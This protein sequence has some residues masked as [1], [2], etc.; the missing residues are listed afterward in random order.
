MSAEQAAEL[1]RQAQALVSTNRA[2]ADR[3]AVQAAAAAQNVRPQNRAAVAAAVV[4][5]ANSWGPKPVVQTA[6]TVTPSND[7]DTEEKTDT[8][9]PNQYAMDVADA[10]KRDKEKNAIAV[11]TSSF[12]NM[13]L[14]SLVPK[15]IGWIKQGY[16]SDAV[17]ALLRDTQEYKDRFPAMQSLAAKNRAISEAQYI[18]FERQ[19]NQMERA[20]GLAPGMLGKDTVTTLLENEVSAQ[21][22]GDRVN[23][24]ASG[25]F[26]ASAEV[27]TQ[28]KDY[29]GID[30][31]GLTSYFLDPD[32]AL[33]LLEKQYVSAQ[34]GAEAALQDFNINSGLAEEIS[35]AG[36]S[37]A[38]AREGFGAASSQKGLTA[39]RGDTVNRSDLVQGNLMNNQQAQKKISRAQ[40]SRTNRFDSGGGFVGGDSGLT[41][42]GSSKTN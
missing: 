39:G 37:N 24:A 4:N 6:P 26:Q 8:A 41:G 34:I 20:Y 5:H 7:T 14:A 18:D 15:A 19:A 3:L 42:L 23:M 16:E 12:T 1:M 21:E 10:A 25:A 36:I 32:K 28:F 11:A 22:L 13:G 17:L 35:M 33:P 27:K 31:G 2:E 9:N 29:Y 38:Q 30:S 40:K